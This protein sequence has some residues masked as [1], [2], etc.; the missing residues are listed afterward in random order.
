MSAWRIFHPACTRETVGIC[1]A[2]DPSPAPFGSSVCHFVSGSPC[3]NTHRRLLPLPE[4]KAHPISAHTICL[5]CSRPLSNCPVT[6]GRRV[7][8]PRGFLIHLTRLCAPKRKC[9]ACLFIF[10]RMKTVSFVRQIIVFWKRN[11]CLVNKIR[12]V[13]WLNAR[14][15]G[16][17][18]N[19]Q[20]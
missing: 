12:L 13:R 5:P 8:N 18:V 7:D 14:R 17:P 6:D 1:E 11:C 19:E 2:G 3:Q 20:R 4:Q 10:G 9:N 15:G 16:C